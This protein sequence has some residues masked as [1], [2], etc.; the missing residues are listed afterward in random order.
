MT[1]GFQSEIL[2]KAFCR[3]SNP[4][5]QEWYVFLYH[6]LKAEYSCLTL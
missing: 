1:K 2:L 4:I 6:L 3:Q 5:L